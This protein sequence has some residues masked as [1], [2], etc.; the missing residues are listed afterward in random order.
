MDNQKKD[1][2]NKNEREARKQQQ[3]QNNAGSEL[4]LHIVEEIAECERF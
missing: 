2:A 3:Q 1:L 4:E